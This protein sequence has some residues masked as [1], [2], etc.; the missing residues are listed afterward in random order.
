[1]KMKVN[2]VFKVTDFDSNNVEILSEGRSVKVIID[3]G[4][5][6]NCTDKDT[7]HSMKV[8]STKLEKSNAKIYPYASKMLLKL[9]GVSHFNVVVIGKVHKLILH[10]IDG[11]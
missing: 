11:Q 1:M 3:S 5:S 6:V 10:I 4:A 9:L 8:S 7:Y 2:H